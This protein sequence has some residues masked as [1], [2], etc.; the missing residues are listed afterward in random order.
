MRP[1]D[2]EFDPPATVRKATAGD[3]LRRR[4]LVLAAGLGLLWLIIVRD[5][6]LV[7]MILVGL[8][9]FLFGVL[10]LGLA[11]LPGLIGVKVSAAIGRAASSRREAGRWPDE[12][13]AGKSGW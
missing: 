13:E 12:D 11:I 9:A 1:H 10:V 2:P 3:R 6:G 5:T 7:W 4:S 8:G